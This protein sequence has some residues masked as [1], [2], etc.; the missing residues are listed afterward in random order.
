MTGRIFDFEFFCTACTG[1]SAA[2]NLCASVFVVAASCVCLF[3]CFEPRGCFQCCFVFGRDRF[4]L[5]GGGFQICRLYDSSTA[6][7]VGEGAGRGHGFAL[8]RPP[9]LRHVGAG[10]GTDY[11]RGWAV[12]LRYLTLP[13]RRTLV[14]WCQTGVLRTRCWRRS[15]AVLFRFLR[16]RL[17][18]QRCP[19]GHAVEARE[20]SHS[21]ASHRACRRCQGCCAS[22]A[23]LL[24]LSRSGLRRHR[25]SGR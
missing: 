10:A 21:S 14:L 24:R 5:V 9:Y 25:R 13:A 18:R 3:F 2:W 17:S 11:A 1:P 6:R 22:R 7:A 15:R 8:Q 16:A 19:A 20:R 12:R 23:M 4:E